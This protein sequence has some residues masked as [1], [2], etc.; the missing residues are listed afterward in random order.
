VKAEAIFDRWR[1][2]KLWTKDIAL[3]CGV[4]EARVRHLLRN[5]LPLR[6]AQWF[7]RWRTRYKVIFRRVMRMPSVTGWE[8]VNALA[9]DVHYHAKRW[10]DL[11]GYHAK[12]TR[13]FHQ[14]REA[15]RARRCIRKVRLLTAK[16]GYTPNEV[17][18]RYAGVTW[19]LVKRLFGSYP[20][21]H[22]QAGVRPN[23]PGWPTDG[24]PPRA[25]HINVPRPPPPPTPVAAETPVPIRA[26]PKGTR[27]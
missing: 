6:Y 2:S 24:R 11:L 5:R 14:R 9:H 18:L 19:V 25:G 8:M 10:A 27:G 20:E 3:A 1:T 22:R 26:R 15:Q 23:R 13:K 12:L 21:F 17:T 7:Q 16:L 4:P